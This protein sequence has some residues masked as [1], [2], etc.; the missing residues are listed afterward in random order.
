MTAPVAFSLRLD[1]KMCAYGLQWKVTAKRD[2]L[3]F[4]RP[5]SNWTTKQ[6]VV[7]MRCCFHVI[8]NVQLM[9]G[10][11]GKIDVDDWKRNTR[12]KHCS[13]ETNV[14]RWFW[15]VVDDYDE[16][17][18]ARLLQFVTGSS[19]VPLQGFK[20]LQG[21]VT[22]R[23]TSRLIFTARLRPQVRM[24]P[25]RKA[26][27]LQSLHAAAPPVQSEYPY[28]VE[29]RAAAAMPLPELP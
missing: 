28:P 4:V 21:S 13:A 29:R 3:F 14:V 11:L 12:L 10:G 16:E 18:R 24:P 2:W 27:E 6:I 19:R 25:I 7:R 8:C 9:I 26:P 5:T 22:V 15:R 20:S 1:T 17:H 23:E